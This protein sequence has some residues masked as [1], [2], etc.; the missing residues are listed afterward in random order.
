MEAVENRSVVNHRGM[1]VK[2][3]TVCFIAAPLL[4]GLASFD[5]GEYKSIG[6]IGGV[7]NTYGIT[8]W[9]GSLLG[10]AWLLWQ[11]APR[12]ASIM[13]G[14]GIIG[15]V[16]GSNFILVA[17]I[18]RKLLIDGVNHELLWLTKGNMASANM[19]ASA[20]MGMW[21]PI[22]LI[23][24][25]IGF[26]RFKLIPSWLGALICIMGIF[27]PLGRIPGNPI[28]IHLTDILMFTVMSIFS[29]KFMR[30]VQQK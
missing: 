28:I 6:S 13:A 17:M 22:T 16:G 12:F 4:M 10:M 9:I 23:L 30:T 20:A 25:G 3:F 18:R 1:P 11:K 19:I 29:W 2:L 14:L 15:C 5:Y 24:F 8:I 26:I 21:F 27:F 7:L